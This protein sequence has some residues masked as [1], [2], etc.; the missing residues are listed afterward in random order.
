M[1]D[2]DEDALLNA[3]HHLH[4]DLPRQGPGSDAT[5]RHL[6]AMAGPLPHRPRVLDVGCGPGRSSLVLAAVA[7]ADVIAIDTHQPFLDQLR[8]AA[9][10]QNLT[11]RIHVVN[12]SM[13]D[14]PYP[15]Q[16][17]DMIW[18][19]GSI[20]HIGFDHALRIWRRLLTPGGALIVTE[21]E[22]TTPDPAAE[23]RAYWEQIYSLRTGT[24]NTAAA[25]AAGY[26]VVGTFRL[27]DNDWFDEYYEPLESRIS[28]AD[29]S[30]AGMNHAV[31][32]I[33]Q[34]IDMRRAYSSDYAYTGYILR[35]SAF[36]HVP[37]LEAKG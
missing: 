5:T 33:R 26:D 8:K 36:H 10:R 15:D 16:T 9:A 32:G 22:W 29:L 30:I 11:D 14:L 35:P 27:P 20:Y 19:E 28:H 31:A 7:E 13:A 25:R 12:V 17:F 24:E 37:P 18:A 1:P 2:L 34:E 6:L 21:C 4:R 3:F 23:L